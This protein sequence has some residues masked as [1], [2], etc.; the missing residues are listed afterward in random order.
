MLAP[1]ASARAQNSAPD[2]IEPESLPPGPLSAAAYEKVGA[3]NKYLAGKY[4]P[5]SWSDRALNLLTDAMKIPANVLTASERSEHRKLTAK[6][7]ATLFPQPTADE[8][9]LSAMLSSPIG[10][11]AWVATREAG[12]SR[13]AQDLALAIGLSAEGMPMVAGPRAG[14]KFLNAQTELAPIE[15]REAAIAAEA[16]KAR[17]EVKP[18]AGQKADELEA[19]VESPSRRRDPIARRTPGLGE[20]AS[21]SELVRIGA[22]PGREGVILTDD[23]APARFYDDMFYL[24]QET[25]VEFALT[26]EKGELVL[27]S[28]AYSHVRF[29]PSAELIAHTHPVGRQPSESDLEAL[30][31]WWRRVGGPAPSADIIW[32]YGPSHVT[33]YGPTGVRS[34]Q[35]DE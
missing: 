10:T 22:M 6:I 18:A 26:R 33:T 34:R 19:L 9:R 2:P 20:R 7:I 32:G 11:I 31:N 13:S 16:P 4:D 29:P 14:L 8:A 23:V 28:G 17:N 24:S 3:R 30:R 1:T 35:R 27:R 15:A 21:M 25:K 5:D 12:G